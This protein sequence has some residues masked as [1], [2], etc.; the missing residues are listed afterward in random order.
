VAFSFD[1]IPA[2]LK[3]GKP[4]LSPPPTFDTTLTLHPEFATVG[5]GMCGANKR[6]PP[7]QTAQQAL[8]SIAPLNLRLFFQMGSGPN[9]G[10]GNHSRGN[11]KTS[12]GVRVSTPSTSWF[13]ADAVNSGGFS[14]ICLLSAQR[15]YLAFEG[16][17]P[18]GA[19]ESCVGGTA[20]AQW[21]PPLG[22]LWNQWMTPLTPFTFA[23]ALWD[24]GENDF[25]HGG[26]YYAEAFPH[27]IEQWRT[28]FNDAQLPFVY[29]EMDQGP[30]GYSQDFWLGQRNATSLANVG[31]AVTT[32]IQRALHPPDKQDVASRLVLEVRRIAYSDSAIPIRPEVVAIKASHTGFVVT[33]SHAVASQGAVFAGGRNNSQC[34]NLSD[35]S[36]AVDLNAIHPGP[37]NSFSTPRA[38]G[39]VECPK[40]EIDSTGTVIT[41]SCPRPD[42]VVQINGH[43]SCYLYSNAGL[44]VAPFCVNC[45]DT[46]KVCRGIAPQKPPHAPD[47]YICKDKKC[48]P[49]NRR[50]AYLNNHCD[51]KCSTG[52][53]SPP[54]LPPPSPPEGITQCPHIGPNNK[55]VLLT[56][57]PAGYMCRFTRC[58]FEYSDSSPRESCFGCQAHGTPACQPNLPA[59]TL[60]R[61]KP[62]VLIVGDSIS[63]GYVF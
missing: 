58:H 11:C 45:N 25:K 24:Q 19:V 37:G 5:F 12:T 27:M 62:N 59:I 13:T 57:C 50:G 43:G 6:T 49:D 20:V 38:P 56:S 48:V 32:D 7:E 53:P 23:A 33:F 47:K 1:S 55:S 30:K 26:E 28:A 35:D 54:P 31:F 42:S 29:V 9:G 51:G 18:V 41:V 44:P 52:P 4:C 8:D 3:V 63:H 22:N 46:Q 15:L 40:Y 34:G 2:H 21:T 10:S 39:C 36:A 16:H 61:T 17:M 60:S 14:A